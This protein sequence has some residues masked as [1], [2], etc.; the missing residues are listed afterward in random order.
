VLSRVAHIE[1]GYMYG[2][3]AGIRLSVDLPVRRLGWATAVSSWILLATAVAAWLLLGPV[4]NGA[5]GSSHSLV[6]IIG[7]EALTA[8]VVATLTGLTLS[9]LPLSF[10]DGYDIFTWHKGVW[11]L[12]YGVT[13]LTFLSI[14]ARPAWITTTNTTPQVVW[15]SALVTFAAVSVAVW[16]AMQE[17]RLATA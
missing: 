5:T 2:L 10:F 4:R 12:T 8:L 14:V 15:V 9:L 11:L 17:K 1:P 16:H 7:A 3:V 6:A 13:L